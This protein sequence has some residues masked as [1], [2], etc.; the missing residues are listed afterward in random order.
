[1]CKANWEEKE[2]EHSPRTG[3]ALAGLRVPLNLNFSDR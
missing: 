1:M 3:V 2:T